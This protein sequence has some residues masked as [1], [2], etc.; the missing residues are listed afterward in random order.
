MS[1]S[2]NRNRNDLEFFAP[3]FSESRSERNLC[4]VSWNLSRILHDYLAATFPG[5]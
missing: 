1:K 2:Q 3:K 5:N 4:H